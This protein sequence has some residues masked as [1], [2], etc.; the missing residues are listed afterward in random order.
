MKAKYFI[1][2]IFIIVS[3][4]YLGMAPEDTR[5]QEDYQ[6]VEKVYEET[7]DTVWN[8]KLVYPQIQGLGDSTFENEI[9][10]IIKK[11][12]FEDLETMTV[13]RDEHGKEFTLEYDYDIALASKN[14]ISIIYR[15]YSHA[16]KNSHP[17]SRFRTANVDLQT[18]DELRIDDLVIINDTFVTRFNNERRYSGRFE[19]DLNYDSELCFQSQLWDSDN[20]MQQIRDAEVYIT[21][22]SLGL[23]FPIIHACGD[24][25][26]VEIPWDITL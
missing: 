23:S 25:V 3:V 11:N 14:L 6:L 1:I 19:K 4:L 15:G 26:E 20:L 24:H 13:T 12:I 16:S 2:V 10:D 18:G 9:N 5:I 7:G 22:N 21:K 8:V 17:L